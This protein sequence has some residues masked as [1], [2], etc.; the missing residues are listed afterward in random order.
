MRIRLAHLTSYQYQGPAKSII[1]LL[2][3]T[4]RSHEGQHVVRWRVEIDADAKLNKGED[5]LGNVIHTIYVNG[6]VSQL[7]VS[8]EGEVETWE[9]HGV[10]SGAVERFAP[11]VFLRDTPLT[12]ADAAL[13]TFAHDVAGAAGD[14]VLSAMH[15]LTAAIHQEMTFDTAATDAGASA[16]QAFALK[17]GVC[18]DLTHVFVAAARALGVPARYVSGHLAREDGV[19][20]QEA[21]HAWAEAYTP[22]LGWVGFDPTNSMSPTPSYIRLAVGLDYLGA[23]PVRGSR[24]GGGQE[25]MDV[26]LHVS[27]AAR[28]TQA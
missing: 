1:Q 19:V 15:E 3:L 7:A 28:Q 18:Q 5:A 2:R 9:T 13:K 11:E 21:A 14:D 20:E 26:K 16:A 10:I 6:P 4:P 25:H 8:V 23:A 27:H 24:V 12:Q 22:G 17:R